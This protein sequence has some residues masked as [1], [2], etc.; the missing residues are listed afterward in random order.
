M[1]ALCLGLGSVLP[2]AAGGLAQEA[3][4]AAGAEAAESVY[5]DPDG[6]FTVPVPTNWTIEAR[7]GFVALT[8]PD[9]DYHVYAMAI[10]EADPE[11]ALRAAWELVEPDSNRVAVESLEIPAPPGIDQF[12]V[13]RYDDGLVSG[14]AVEAAAQLVGELT[15]VL[16]F[17][18]DVE[19][20]V[21]RASQIGII[22]TGFTI[23]AVERTDLSGVM[24]RRFTPAMLAELESYI[25]EA[26]VAN[27]VPGAAVAIVQNGDVVYRQGFGVREVGS[28]A[29]VTPETLM[30][31]GSISKSMTTLM[32]ATVVDDEQ[33]AWDTPAAEILPSF[34]VADSAL[35]SRV[36]MRELVC[37]CTGVPRRDLEFIFNADELEPADVIASLASFE[38]F[39][40]IGE[41]FQYSNQMVAA[42]GYL[43]TLAAGGELPTLAD[44]YEAA[45]EERVFGP[46]GMD[47][48]TFSM[49]EVAANPNH[50]S[51]H[52][53]TFDGTFEVQPL[54]AEALLTPVAPSASAW[55]NVD[56][57][58]LYLLTELSDGV[59]PDGERV[60]SA[61][62]LHETWRPQVP[63][64]D[65]VSYGLG[66]FVDSFKSQQMIQHSGNTIGFTADLVFLPESDLG[67]VIL[68][69]ASLANLF[70]ESVRH[71]ALE[72]AFDLEPEGEE[73][74]EFALERQAELRAQGAAVI[75]TAP[76]AAAVAPYL[77]TYVSPAFGTVSLGF[78]DSRLV[79]DAG[80]F[81]GEVRPIKPGADQVANHLVV[82][83]P[84]IGLL[85]NLREEGGEPMF[86]VVD[87]ITLEVY[88]FTPV[89]EDSADA[90]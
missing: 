77:G 63:V 20:S 54:A 22:A 23:L 30:M 10:A 37:A 81:Q 21:R 15:F 26:L 42:G 71:R 72:I 32:M 89:A 74:V 3:T 17:E 84:V 47:E 31:V 82:D 27:D 68:T 52:A 69:N 61:A 41:A 58:A 44:D 5:E 34:A 73:F 8:E 59:A 33:M 75:G 18:G 7:D 13:V 16:L 66:W 43:A 80:E 78:A 57:L 2:L 56:D 51:S 1:L 29:P 90:P 40:P 35:S 65:S 83:G 9:G 36:T 24:P 86:E 67:I 85:L 55:S 49:A 6:R 38:F 11:A 4:P 62:S 64:S 48:T 79:L 19:T 76:T 39:T 45:M 12:V 88:P 46:I 14:R 60:V 50:A 70:T 53:R 87:Q 28:A 25:D